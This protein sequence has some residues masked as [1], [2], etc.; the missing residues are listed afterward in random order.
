[1]RVCVIPIVHRQN[2]IEIDTKLV[3]P[4]MSV[5]THTTVEDTGQHPHTHNVSTFYRPTAASSTRVAV[6]RVSLVGVGVRT[7]VVFTPRG[8][9]CDRV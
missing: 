3:L 2:N 8:V 4:D 5:P 1:M 7:Y 6:Y 9:T